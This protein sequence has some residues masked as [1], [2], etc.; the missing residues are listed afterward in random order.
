MNLY[1]VATPIGNL[2]D[3]TLRALETLKTVDFIICEDTRVTSTLLN[4]FNIKKPLLALNEFNEDNMVYEI[5]NRLKTQNGALVSDA[6]TPLISDP[7]Y[8]LV[9]KAREKNFQII[10][11]PGP[12]ALIA[13]LSVSGMPTDKFSFLGFLPKKSLKAKRSLEMTKNLDETVILYES[14]HRITK[15]LELIKE[16]FGDIDISIA[17]EL[18]KKFEEVHLEPITAHLKRFE[19]KPPKGEFVILFSTKTTS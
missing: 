6:G 8:K 4:K 10:P 16:L 14:P 7:G 1:I 18:T 3:I 13:A 19:T 9:K 5:L 12:S 17:R 2:Q 15:T 11:I